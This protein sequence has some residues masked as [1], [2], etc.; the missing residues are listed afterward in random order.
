M[1]S[2][3]NLDSPNLNPEINFPIFGNIFARKTYGLLMLSWSLKGVPGV[4]GSDRPGVPASVFNRDFLKKYNWRYCGRCVIRIKNTS[5][6][7]KKG[8]ILQG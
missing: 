1:C 2:A 6:A 8:T 7:K 5:K 4:G 3:W